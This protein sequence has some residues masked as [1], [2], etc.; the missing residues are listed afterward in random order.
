[1]VT[2]ILA[3]DMSQHFELVTKF[4]THL[5]T[6]P[7]TSSPDDRF[8]VYTSLT[9][10]FS[11]L[12]STIILHTADISNSLRPLEISQYWSDHLQEEFLRQGDL[13]AKQGL[14]ISP[15]MN[16]QNPLKPQVF[17]IPGAN[18]TKRK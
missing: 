18:L 5:Q 6:K 15:F 10:L 13:E 9:H 12:I 3:T 7:F 4:T 11:Q 14:T 2:N 8:V 16:R 1:M 17:T